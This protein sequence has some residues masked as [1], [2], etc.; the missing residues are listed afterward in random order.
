MK[1][2]NQLLALF[3]LLVFVALGLL[4]FRTWVVQKPFAIILFVSDGLVPGH[5]TAARLYEGGGDHKL[6]LETLPHLALIS[7][8]ANDFA[9]PDSP[10][11][12]SAIATGE[13]VNN[14]SVSMSPGEKPLSTIL[15]IAHDEGRG[16]GIIT[17]S[18]LANAGIAAF[19]AHAEK[20]EELEVIGAQFADNARLDV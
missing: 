1:L 6:T 15:E 14:R 16:V 8:H 11:A 19:Y 7:N 2:R 13:K 4:Y 17:T 10:A 3:C 9:V 18:S 20:A 5:L 12:A